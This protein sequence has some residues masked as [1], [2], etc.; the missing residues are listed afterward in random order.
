VTISA[1]GFGTVTLD[2]VNITLNLT[3]NGNFELKPASASGEVTITAEPAPINTT[4]A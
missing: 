3:A 4:H 1:N 2:G